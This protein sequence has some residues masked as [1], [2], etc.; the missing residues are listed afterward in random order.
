MSNDI[1]QLNEK[2]E[3]I[4]K[5][6]GKLTAELTFKINQLAYRE[7]AEEYANDGMTESAYMKDGIESVQWYCAEALTQ[8]VYEVAEKEYQRLLKSTYQK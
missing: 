8:G 2:M 4:F 3:L 7:E 6:A 5:E 1:D